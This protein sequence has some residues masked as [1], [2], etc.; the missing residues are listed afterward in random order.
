M[1][2]AIAFLR[3][4]MSAELWKKIFVLLMTKDKI[5]VIITIR[6]HSNE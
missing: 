2:V 1:A 4:H 5:R 3:W 6:L